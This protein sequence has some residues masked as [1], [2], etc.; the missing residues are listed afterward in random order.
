MISILEDREI[1]KKFGERMRKERLRLDLSQNHV[2]GVVGITL[3]TYRKIEQGNG[4][5]EFRHVVRVLAVLGH[6]AALAELIP[7]QPPELR[8]KDLLAPE[9]KHATPRRRS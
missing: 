3:P 4:S 6:G 2:A 1:L 8:L 7:E 9:R 5:V